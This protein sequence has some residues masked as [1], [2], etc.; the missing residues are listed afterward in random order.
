MWMNGA[1]LRQIWP[2]NKGLESCWACNQINLFIFLQLYTIQCLSKNIYFTMIIFDCFQLGFQTNIRLQHGKFNTS[3]ILPANTSSL[4]HP[5]MTQKGNPFA[6]LWY[7]DAGQVSNCTRQ[8]GS[9]SEVHPDVKD[10]M[11]FDLLAPPS[12][13]SVFLFKPVLV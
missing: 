4:L 12:S 1:E 13:T 11:A 6:F 9:A 2:L 5:I 10:Y 7:H 8:L 3:I